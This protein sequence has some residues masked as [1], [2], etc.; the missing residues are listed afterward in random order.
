M[1][2]GNGFLG[3]VVNAAL[4]ICLSRFLDCLCATLSVQIFARTNFRAD[5]FSRGFIFV[6]GLHLDL[7]HTNF[8]ELTISS[9]FARINFRE[10]SKFAIF[11]TNFCVCTNVYKFSR[12]FIFA[13]GR[14]LD[15][16]R[17]FIFANDGQ[18]AKINPREN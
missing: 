9:K 1:S 13:I 8:R 6:N 3:I 4:E 7:A 16:S 17:G 14:F 2:F 11:Y 10:S 15:I 5:L 12:G 18:F